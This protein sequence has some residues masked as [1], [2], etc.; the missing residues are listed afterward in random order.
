MRAGERVCGW[1]ARVHAEYEQ[2]ADEAGG[3]RPLRGY[4]VLLGAYAASAAALVAAVRRRGP[5]AGRPDLTDL[6][7]VST[8]T[9]QLSRTLTKSSVT[10]PLRAPF[11]TYQGTAGPGEILEAPRPG[12]VRHAVGELVS[13]PLCMTQW[14]GTAGLAGLALLPRTTRW[15]AAAM[16]AVAAANALH[17]AYAR[18]QQAAE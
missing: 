13:C 8:A 2:G 16:T 7:L 3:A 15:T 1:W 5:L 18:A 4:T 10:A 12:P 14:V 6:A 9:F 17:L 11:T